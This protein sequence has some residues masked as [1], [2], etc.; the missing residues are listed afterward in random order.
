MELIFVYN[1]ESGVFNKAIAFAHKIVSP[2]TYE[3]SLCSIIHGKFSVHDKWADFIISLKIPVKFL[4]KN[5]FE[6]TYPNIS[7]PYPV[8][9]LWNGKNIVKLLNASEIG[10]VNKSGNL[11][12]LIDLIKLKMLRNNSS[13]SD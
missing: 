5:E 3:C 12:E 7:A 11:S 13:V 6:A 10:D 2:Q 9:Y 8:A 1:A 4:Y